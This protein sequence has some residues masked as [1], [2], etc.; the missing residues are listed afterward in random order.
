MSTPV[1]GY[2]LARVNINTRDG[3]FVEEYPMLASG[4][5][6]AKADLLAILAVRAL[7][8]DSS[9][10]IAN[11]VLSSKSGIANGYQIPHDTFAVPTLIINQNRTGMPVTET[12]IGASADQTSGIEW[13]LD[14][15]P[16]QV[17]RLLRCCRKDWFTANVI[18]QIIS[19][20]SNSGSV[21]TLGS[22]PAAKDLLSNYFSL[23]RD[24][25]ALYEK[26]P[27]SPPAF[28]QFP[29]L[30]ANGTPGLPDWMVIGVSRRKIGKGWPPIK[31][32]QPSFA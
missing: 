29:F 12:A 7:M 4:L 5:D 19:P 22:P 23:V 30:F 21:I 16:K 14:A 13:Q 9:S 1:A 2:W 31:G 8:L 3:G 15:G 11:A 32:R 18:V 20:P 10:S 27:A 28:L 6:V 24:K 17:R 25:T 26:N